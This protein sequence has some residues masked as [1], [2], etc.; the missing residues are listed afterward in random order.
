[1]PNITFHKYQLFL[2]ETLNKIF[3]IINTMNITLKFVIT[4]VKPVSSKILLRHSS[5]CHN[6]LHFVKERV[7]CFVKTLHELR[8]FR[9]R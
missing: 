5:L 7:E 6:F 8:R 4:V 3:I 2:C 1:M 9:Q